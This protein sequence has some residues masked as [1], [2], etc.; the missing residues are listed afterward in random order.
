MN[1]GVPTDRM[2]LI[3][4]APE[5]G[6]FG[7]ENG[8]L[9]DPGNPYR[10]IFHYRINT[11]GAG[12]MPMIGF[13]TPDEEGIELIHD[14]IRSMAPETP[15]PDHTLKPKNVEEAL[16]LMHRIRTGELSK[17]KAQ[18]AIDFCMQSTDPFIIN[19]FAGFTVE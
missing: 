18:K 13:R 6:S 7:I 12:H 14:W 10:S 2:G 15:V 16:A 11:L 19:L 17:A 9:I 1:I 5:K 3:N 8:Y 4:K